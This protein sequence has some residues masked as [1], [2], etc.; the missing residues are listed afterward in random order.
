MNYQVGVAVLCRDCY[1][2][3]VRYG[4]MAS[5]DARFSPAHGSNAT[6]E[7]SISAKGA[8]VRGTVTDADNLPAAGVWV[9]LVPDEPR[10][11]YRHLYKTST[12]DQYGNFAAS[13]L[14]GTNYSVGR[15]WNPALGRIRNF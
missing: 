13:R 1:L 2:K 14:A 7:L 15:K 4:T 9:A 3:E 10:R 6:L 11:A 5:A 12:T 8:Q